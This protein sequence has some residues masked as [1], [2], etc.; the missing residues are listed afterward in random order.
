MFYTQIN[1][2]DAIDLVTRFQTKQGR[3]PFT[4]F[5]IIAT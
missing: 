2:N 5:F 3:F 1:K 4:N